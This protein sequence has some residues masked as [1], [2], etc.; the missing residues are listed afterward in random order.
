MTLAPPPPRSAPSRPR[1]QPL[2]PHPFGA[3]VLPTVLSVTTFVV[4]TVLRDPSGSWTV[5]GLASSSF[6]AVVTLVTLFAVTERR[7]DLVPWLVTAALVLGVADMSYLSISGTAMAPLFAT[8]VLVHI[9]W[10]RPAAPV[11]DRLGTGVEPLAGIT[12]LSAAAA[13]VVLVAPDAGGTIS[14]YGLAVVGLAGAWDA[15]AQALRRHLPAAVV[16]VGAVG[17]AGAAAGL[18]TLTGTR[19]LAFGALVAVMTLGL[20]AGARWIP[21]VGAI[22]LGAMMFTVQPELLADSILIQATTGF[23]LGALVTNLWRRSEQLVVE[24]SPAR[25]TG[26]LLMGVA[27]VALAAQY[28]LGLGGVVGLGVLCGVVVMAW[29]RGAARTGLAAAAGAVVLVLV[30]V[31]PVTTAALVVLGGLSMVATAIAP[32]ALEQCLAVPAARTERLRERA[33]LV[34]W[35]VATT[36]AM[37]VSGAWRTG[38]AMEP[39]P[40]L[41]SLPALVLAA[42][43][44]LAVPVPPAVLRWAALVPLRAALRGSVTALWSASGALVAAGDRASAAALGGLARLTGPLVAARRPPDPPDAPTAGAAAARDYVGP[45]LLWLGCSI[46]VKVLAAS[47]SMAG[48]RWPTQLAPNSRLLFPLDSTGR[49][50]WGTG[51][52]LVVAERG[53]TISDHREAFLPVLPLSLRW[54]REWTGT[55]IATLQ[56]AIA[57]VSGLACVVLFWAWMRQRDVPRRVRWLALVL[58]LVLPW[59]FLLFG[60]GY[61]DPTLV[62]LVLGAFLLVERDRPIAAGVVG[63]VA[64]ATRP[65]GVALIPALVLFELVRSGALRR[66]A[67]G[68]GWALPWIPR[69]RVAVDLRRMRPPQWGVLVSV[70]LIGAFSAWMWHHAGSP[71]Y[72][73]TL[74]EFYGHPPLTHLVA[75][76][77]ALFAPWPSGDISGPHEAVHQVFTA[78]VTLGSLLM[79]PA[80]RRRFGVAYGAFAAMIWIIAWTGSRL[81]TPGGRLLLPMTPFLAVVAATWLVRRPGLSRVVVVTSAVG[82]LTLVVLFTRGGELWLGW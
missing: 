40:F 58:F 55:D 9:A 25:L 1:R 20:L 74:N 17:L 12:A 21:L 56:V 26:V 10:R 2:G 71:L 31:G 19:S 54:L 46:V 32:R 16:L 73:L 70:T 33:P 37:H 68:N 13:L 42:A 79:I 75:W 57:T 34:A 65:N 28:T 53:Y 80:V 4:R 82:S 77:E 8:A 81:F 66:A 59:N 76:S 24:C 5:G 15:A 23:V 52:Y 49:I 47:A 35:L 38:S 6:V 51:D 30:L 39:V 11:G 22:A 50:G 3:V 7:R 64:A 36:A 61:A 43:L 44:V 62:A 41:F 69:D 60:Y 18:D 29:P 78:A 14:G 72:W 27:P 48:G 67:P 63:A 45:V